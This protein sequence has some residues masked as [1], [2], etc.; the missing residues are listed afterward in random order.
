MTAEQI[1][2]CFARDDPYHNFF[3]HIKNKINE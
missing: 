3:Y 2:R 1:A